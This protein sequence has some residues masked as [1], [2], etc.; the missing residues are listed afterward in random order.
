MSIVK[1]IE[2]CLELW[3]EKISMDGAR[4]IPQSNGYLFRELVDTYD[5]ILEQEKELLEGIV[6]YE[7]YGIFFYKMKENY[8]KNLFV[9]V[10]KSEFDIEQL[11]ENV[12]KEVMDGDYDKL[13]ER[14]KSIDAEWLKE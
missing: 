10:H 2:E 14:L 4:Y 1:Y 7:I 6:M 3:P 13:K 8:N 9:D 12:R 5:R 11:V